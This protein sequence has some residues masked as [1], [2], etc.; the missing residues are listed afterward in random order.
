MFI[1]NDKNAALMC[2]VNIFRLVS[3]LFFPQMV[4]MLF[5]EERHLSFL[6]KN[7]T[8][9]NPLCHNVQSFSFMVSGFALVIFISSLICG[10]F[11]F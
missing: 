3:L 6:G 2:T 7:G 10:D 5:I 8:N 9:E 4:K 1:H 11:C